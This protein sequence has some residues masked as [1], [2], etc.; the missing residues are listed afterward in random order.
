[1]K[2]EVY[3]GHMYSE[4]SLIARKLQ[5]EEENL[6]IEFEE[7][8][9]NALKCHILEAYAQLLHNVKSSEEQDKISELIFS[10]KRLLYRYFLHCLE[11]EMLDSLPVTTREWLDIKDEN[12]MFSQTIQEREISEWKRQKCPWWIGYPL[13]VIPKQEAELHAS[14]AK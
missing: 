2:K 12:T 13:G 3:W 11:V 7:F 5:V 1:M 9:K 10:A 6:P 8:Y 14:G 4:T